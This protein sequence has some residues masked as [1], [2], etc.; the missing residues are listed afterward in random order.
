MKN[1]NTKILF[2][3]YNVFGNVI[4]VGV[5]NFE[6]VDTCVAGRDVEMY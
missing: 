1:S 4:I 6:E 3:Y 2:G 5:V